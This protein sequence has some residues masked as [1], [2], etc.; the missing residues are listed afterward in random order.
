MKILNGSGGNP[1][2]WYRPPEITGIGLDTVYVNPISEYS[3]YNLETDANEYYDIA[4]NNTDIVQQ[5]L[6]EMVKIKN[7]GVP[8]STDQSGCPNQT[9]PVYPVCW[10]SLVAVVWIKRQYCEKYS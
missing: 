2:G 6:D 9:T 1:R 10:E 3:L 4:D 7:T 8:Q 5:L